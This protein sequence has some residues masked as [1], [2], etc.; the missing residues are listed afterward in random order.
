MDFSTLPRGQVAW[1]NLINELSQTDDRVERHYLEL[2]SDVE[3]HENSGRA[4]VVKFILGAANRDPEQAERYFNGCALMVLGVA[5]NKITGIPAFEAHQLANFVTR[6]IGTP[7]P[8]WDFERIPAANGRDVIIIIVDP[9]TGDLWTCHADGDRLADGDIYVRADGETRRAKGREIR[10]MI[11]RAER[12]QQRIGAGD[13]QVSIAGKAI[14]HASTYSEILDEYI[15]A[16]RKKLGNPRVGTIESAYFKINSKF[17]MASDYRSP[18]TYTE[19]VDD[20]AEDVRSAWPSLLDHIAGLAGR[21]TH[22]EIR[23]NSETFLEDVRVEIYIE[24]AVRAVDSVDRESFNLSS[25][26]PS[27]PYPW[28]TSTMALT[29]SSRSA[30]LPSFRNPTPH[31]EP[32]VSYQNGNSTTL[33]TNLATLRPRSTELTD[34]DEFTLTAL[35][36]GANELRATWRITARGHHRVYEG[37]FVIP[38]HQLNDCSEGIRSAIFPDIAPDE[39]DD[40]DEDD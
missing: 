5:H 1:T 16:A 3:L 13:L 2:K 38:I 34:N 28:G 18:E 25:Q 7:G 32:M 21:G 17:I 6:F 20:W 33:T 29:L 26:L 9:P 31:F 27:L 15:A 40:D 24:G 10:T 11:E 4:K 35:E 23:N 19:E 36:P 30:F 14:L 12:N 8:R 22:I 37:E 39:E